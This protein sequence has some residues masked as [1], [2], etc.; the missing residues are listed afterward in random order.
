M[1]NRFLIIYFSILG[2]INSSSLANEQFN[3]DVA[4]IEITENG[5]RFLGSKGGVLTT[6]DGLFIKAE[7]FNY[8]KISKK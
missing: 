7:K 1:K 8:D 6:E 2:F 4:E 3:F 5:N